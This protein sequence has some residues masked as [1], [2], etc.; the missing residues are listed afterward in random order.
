[1]VEESKRDGAD[2]N[3]YILNVAGCGNGQTTPV[4]SNPVLGA[5]PVPIR[6]AC[7]VARVFLQG[8]PVGVPCLHSRR[9]LSL[10]G[11]FVLRD[12]ASGVR[13]GYAFPGVVNPE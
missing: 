5:S 7:T 11:V 8:D 2:I 9:I 3:V 6:L 12:G 4:S 1:M 13:A 10:P